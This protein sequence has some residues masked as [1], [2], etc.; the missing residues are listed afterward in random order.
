M[1][2]TDLDNIWQISSIERQPE[3]VDGMTSVP[4][5]ETR[6]VNLYK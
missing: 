2:N 3:T 6:S 5:T 1:Y 4:L